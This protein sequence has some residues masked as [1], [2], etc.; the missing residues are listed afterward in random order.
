MSEGDMDQQ[1]LVREN[2]AL[3][4]QVAALRA[5][6]ERFRTTLYSIGDA[7]ISAD[8]QGN[9]LQMN[10]VAEALTGW[11]E[12]EAKG[13][14]TVEVFKIVNE[15]TRAEVEN[16][17]ARVLREGAVVGLANHAVLIAKDGT[18][19]PIADSGAPIRDAAGHVRGVVLVFRDQSEERAAQRALQES[20]R[21]FHDAIRYLDEGYYSCAPD[22]LLKEHN[23]AFARILGFEPGE[24]LRGSQLP[25][26]W[27]SLD[28]R[29]EYL[30]ELV[31]KG[32]IRNYLINAKSING[33]Q[34]V[35]M[36]N[37]HLVK[38]ESNRPAGI[39][40]T[41]TDFTERTRAEQQIAHLNAELEAKVVEQTAQLKDQMELNQKILNSSPV[42]IF[43]CCADGPCVLAN[44]AVAKISG[45][46]VEKML[47]LNFHELAE[48]KKNGLYDKAQA[49]LAT[50]VNQ[51]ADVHLT[52]S[53]GRDA[54]LSYTFTTFER[55][56]T[57][58]F[59]MLVEDITERKRMEMA[60]RESEERTRTTLYAIGDGVM[61]TDA[62]GRVA[63][64]NPVAEVLTGWR[65]AEARGQPLAQVFQIVNEETRA[66]LESPVE[67][68]LREGAV[69]GLANHT[70]LIAKDGTE[71]PVADSAAP[72]RGEG[73]ET[74][75]VVLVFR[76]QTEER[77][78]K[79]ALLRRTAQLEES[80]KE[81]EAFSY[82][83]SHDLRAPLRAISGFTR[84]LADDYA[85]HMDT[86]GKRVC[87][88]I[89][90]ETG[91]MGRLIDDLLAFSRLG[92]A[93]MNLS[94]ID[95]GVMASSV[96][97]E[98][99][100]PES[101]KRIDFLVGALPEAVADP[102]LM[103]QMWMN[104]LGNA[105]KF[106]SKRERA[107]IKVSGEQKEGEH[108][109]A[110]EDNGAGFDM[111]YVHKLFGVFQR[112]HSSTEFEGTGVGL[113]LVQRVIHR[114]GGRVWAEGETDRGAAFYAAL[115]QKGA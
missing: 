20:E 8:A 78:A 29:T 22:G 17:V 66:E 46:P 25:D 76:D 91:R 9:V 94:R 103:R 15:E 34:L 35:V 6:A 74:T 31:T 81:L 109:Y 44:P 63:R 96:F 108:V 84:I 87:S 19:R 104:L 57:P 40:G 75:G 33:E 77:A 70:L 97:Y 101:R 5:E 50:G 100:T 7:V 52:T 43:A 16:P 55:G 21:K 62:A 54:W 105:V 99:T 53:F 112:L 23:V 86:E 49:A 41:F 88:V 61:S 18:E 30:H 89:R 26:F 37:S 13:Q 4:R 24:D 32:F 51:H 98:L 113:A 36:A 56:G 115:P 27:Q 90:E 1:Q 85:P 80:N 83:V 2:E 64:M 65:E 111:Q 14:P 102:S 47:Q 60:L 28:D 79:K 73:G 95:M 3:R 68:A 58:H 48:W 67:H 69:V 92:R 110:V 39:E 10:H 72:I 12:A 107:I 11:S 45:A 38:D 71:R 82:S 114:H 42:G 59:L 106:S 93:E